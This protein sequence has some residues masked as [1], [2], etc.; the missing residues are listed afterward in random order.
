MAGGW[1]LDIFL[2]T[3]PDSR[4]CTGAQQCAPTDSP[5]YAAGILI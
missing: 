3:I 5:I 1:W 2:V 4:L